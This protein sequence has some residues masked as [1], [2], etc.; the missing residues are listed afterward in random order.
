MPHLEPERVRDLLQRRP[1]ASPQLAVPAVAE[2]L[3]G[4]AR[5]P[6]T[7]VQNRVAIFDDEYGVAGLVAAQV[8]VGRVRPE[9]VVGVV[10]ADFEGSGRHHE[11]LPGEGIS[12]L[13]AALRRPLRD[14][15]TWQVEVAIAPPL[16]HEGGVRLGYSLVV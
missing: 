11:T 7:G 15:V 14:R 16:T 4:L 2:E 6:R 12:E 3:V 10:G 13:G 1:T 9:P 5:R 8:D